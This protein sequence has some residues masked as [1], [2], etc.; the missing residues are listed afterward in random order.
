M[1]SPAY[2]ISIPHPCTQSWEQ[3]TPSGNGR[4]CMACD[5]VV[6]DF[7]GMSDTQVQEFFL[8]HHG[9]ALCGRFRNMQLDQI[10]IQV[11]SY[12]LSK[13]IPLWKKFLVVLL[14]CFGSSMFSVDVAVAGN[15]HLP[16]VMELNK[17]RTW[18]NGPG[19][20]RKKKRRKKNL[21]D[22]PRMME[23]GTTL[24]YTTLEPT[25]E[26]KVLS[27]YPLP[28]PKVL[29]IAHLAL[30]EKD[31]GNKEKPV[32]KNPFSKMEFLVP[33]GWRK[34]KRKN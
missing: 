14:I 5:K 11:P 1:T 4:H 7:T 8:Q 13:P 25:N 10:R 21:W 30:T 33:A 34:R 29:P 15:F 26:N 16:G 17:E 19:K 24:G 6:T 9:K 12:I 27:S 18:K 22:V 2:Q 20:V 32:R 3:M 31:R 23:V 28:I